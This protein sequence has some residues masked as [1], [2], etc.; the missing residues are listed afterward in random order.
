[1]RMGATETRL[2]G[3]P[4]DILLRRMR[5]AIERCEL[6]LSDTVVFTEAA[7]GAYV[8]TPVLAAMAGAS[9]VIAMA[10]SS[11]YGSVQAITEA[12]LELAAR[13]CVAPRIEVVTE[14]R[15]DLIGAADI[16]TNS[17]HVRPIGAE[18]VGWMKPSAV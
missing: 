18:V 10:R 14:K 3:Y 11:R 2:P 8:V 7:S 15:A 13:A 16:V 9:R 5:A 6:D 1:M 4:T 12:T 17:G